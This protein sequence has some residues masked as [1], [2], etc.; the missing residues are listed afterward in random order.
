MASTSSM[1]NKR[2][3]VETQGL[4]EGNETW[5]F[6]DTEYKINQ[7]ISFQW[8]QMFQYF[9]TEYYQMLLQDDLCM[10]LSKD[11]YKKNSKYGLYRVVAKPL[12]ILCL[13]VVEWMTRKVDHSNRILLNFE[14]KHVARYQPY[15]IHRMYHFKEPQIKITQ[16]RLQSKVETIDYLAQMKG[17]WDEGNF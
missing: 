2:K 3:S 8:N 10:E 11:V 5:V 7:K 17:W 14:E 1:K 4:V 12:I 6:I 15:A 16:E 13:D 9:L